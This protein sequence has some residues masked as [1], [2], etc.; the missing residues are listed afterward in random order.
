[1][2]ALLAFSF[3]PVTLGFVAARPEIPPDYDAVAS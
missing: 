1:M 2:T 3:L